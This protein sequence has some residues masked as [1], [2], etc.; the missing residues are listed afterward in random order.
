MSGRSDT[1]GIS[2]EIQAVI[3]ERRWRTDWEATQQRKRAVEPLQ[4]RNIGGENGL[5]HVDVGF[6]VT[7]GVGNEQVRP[8]PRISSPRTAPRA[9]GFE[10]DLLG[11]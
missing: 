2:L 3:V 8:T 1:P 7:I 11:I 10:A 5:Q 9:A 6:T 4:L